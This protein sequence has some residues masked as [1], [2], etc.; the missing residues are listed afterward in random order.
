MKTLTLGVDYDTLSHELRIPLTGILGISE[1]LSHEQS[2]SSEQRAQ[3][4]IIHEAG[5]RLLAMVEQILN[6]PEQEISQLRSSEALLVLVSS[7][8]NQIH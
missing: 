8:P 4:A 7:E 2:L 5:D 1:L 3:I 6:C